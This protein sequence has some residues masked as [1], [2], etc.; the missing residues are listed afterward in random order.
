MSLAGGYFWTDDLPSKGCKPSYQG[1]ILGRILTGDVEQM[2]TRHRVC[3]L[4]PCVQ[5]SANVEFV[6]PFG[7]LRDVFEGQARLPI[8]SSFHEHVLRG[9]CLQFNL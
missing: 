5:N 9:R 2:P 1:C 8:S 4:R 6:T 7:R 3:F